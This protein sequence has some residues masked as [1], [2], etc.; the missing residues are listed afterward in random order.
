MSQRD[1]ETSRTPTRLADYRAPAWWVDTIALRFELDFDSTLVHARLSVRRNPDVAP[2]P[3]VLD[4][5]GLELLEVALDER[6]LTPAEYVRDE[7]TLRLEPT[8]DRAAVETRVR[9]SP[10]RNTALE[11]LYR[12][13]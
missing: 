3:L 1:A 8:A 9:I 2:A 5:E 4:G 12:S 7:H 6:T 13:G 10:S 11:G